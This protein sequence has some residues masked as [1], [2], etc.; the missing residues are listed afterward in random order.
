MTADSVRRAARPPTGAAVVLVVEDEALVAMLVRDT[1]EGAGY[2]A[3]WSPDGRRLAPACP[4][5]PGRWPLPIGAAVVDL[6]LE[7][8]P[9]GREVVRALR[10]RSPALPVVV[11]T[12]FA[13]EGPQADLRGLGGPTLRLQKPVDCDEMLAWLDGALRRFDPPSGGSPPP[14]P[15]RRRSDRSAPT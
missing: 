13:P 3:V 9:D 15:R 8:G 7:A 10:A 5:S 11:A 2:A 6:R 14:H 4:A 12:G 1:L